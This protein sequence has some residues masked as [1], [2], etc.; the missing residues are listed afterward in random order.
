MILLSES[1]VSVICSE[2]S[3][4]G[5]HRCNVS[6]CDMSIFKTDTKQAS[7]VLSFQCVGGFVLCEVCVVL[8]LNCSP[9]GGFL[10]FMFFFQL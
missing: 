10:S 8:F 9:L 4:N 3:W 5:F 6:C 2:Y 7:S 1:L